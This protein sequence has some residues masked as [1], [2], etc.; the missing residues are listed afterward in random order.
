MP[1]PNPFRIEGPAAIN[2][3][4]GRTS[5]MMLH[6]ILDAH[7]GRLPPGVF[8]FFC[9][10]GREMPATFDFVRDMAQNWGVHIQWLEYR[11][12]PE[13]GRVW[14]E[15]VSHNSASR[16]GEPFEMLVGGKAFLPNPVTR[17]CTIELKIRATRR[18][19][20]AELGWRRWISVVGFRSDEMHRVIKAGIRNAAHTERFRVFCPLAKARMTKADHV[21]PFWEKQSFDLGLAGSWEGNCDGCFLKSRGAIERMFRDHPERM[22]WWPGMEGIRGQEIGVS[23]GTFDPTSAR[24]RADRDGY[25]QIAEHVRRSPRI[26]GLDP[27]DA[28]D[29]F[30]DCEGGCGV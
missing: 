20:D 9:N 14:T 18:W 25:R 4:G 16:Q 22:A 21:T 1:M 8:A 19:I 12:D 24:F 11:R 29:T 23:I 17:F 10:T 5:G 15:P 30:A 2:V 3:S 13:T 6:H 27:E 28:W 26:P 7:D